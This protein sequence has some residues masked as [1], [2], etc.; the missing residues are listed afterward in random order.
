MISK[1][2]LFVT[3]ACNFDCVYCRKGSRTKGHETHM[4]L[5]LVKKAIGG[6][7]DVSNLSVTLTG[8]EPGL[9]PH[10]E[11]IV[12]FLAGKVREI[13]LMT[14]GSLHEPYLPVMEDLDFIGF[15]IDGVDG[16]HGAQRQGDAGSVLE[17]MQSF[18]KYGPT[19]S[20][21][22]VVTQSNVDQIPQIAKAVQEFG[23][24]MAA[25]GAVIPIPGV[26]CPNSF[27]FLADKDRL[28]GISLIEWVK[29]NVDIECKVL[30]SLWTRGGVRFCSTLLDL[31]GISVWP[32]GRVVFCCDVEHE[33]GVVG[34]LNKDSIEIIAERAR[35]VC[36]AI[37][38]LRENLFRRRV[39]FF[40]GFDTCEFCNQACVVANRNL[41]LKG[42]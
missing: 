2:G 33:G 22:T 39:R 38:S 4:P 32:D 34:D 29:W 35:S 18:G 23:G 10:L 21:I 3:D 25:F 8:G 24:E 27:G 20:S 11:S 16:V 9:S 7:R 15:S 6:L 36:N 1:L 42:S 12:R 40:D 13:G 17:T 31:D 28:R 14:N 30:E 26:E 19:T 37:M 41:Y 5:A